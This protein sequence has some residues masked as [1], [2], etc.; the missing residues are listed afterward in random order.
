MESISRFQLTNESK[1]TKQQLSQNVFVFAFY[2]Y[3]YIK[4][5]KIS[6]FLNRMSAIENN[7]ET[8]KKKQKKIQNLKCS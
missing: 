8:K 4:K 7:D 5:P 6:S 3:S 1:Q 2:E